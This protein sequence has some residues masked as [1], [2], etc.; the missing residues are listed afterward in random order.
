MGVIRLSK[1]RILVQNIYALESLAHVD[2]L[3]L[4]KTGTLTN[5]EMK[6]QEKILCPGIP[7][8]MGRLN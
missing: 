1:M 2:V 4:D 3:C 5:G 6:V 8:A 7:T